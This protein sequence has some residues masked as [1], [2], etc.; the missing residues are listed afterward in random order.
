MAGV[1]MS[2]VASSDLAAQMKEIARIDGVSASQA[3]ARA[4]ALGAMLP[5]SA[6]RM[7]RRI[8][9]EGDAEAQRELAGLVARAVAQAGQAFVQ[10]QLLRQAEGGGAADLMTEEALAEEAVRA[11]EGYIRDHAPAPSNATRRTGK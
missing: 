8:L 3:A 11:V 10:R 5:A 6:R 7:F 9:N 4:A 1:T 2:F